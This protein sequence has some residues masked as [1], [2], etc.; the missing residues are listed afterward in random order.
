MGE[1]KREESV[2]TP[3]SRILDGCWGEDVWASWGWQGWGDFDGQT[4]G[5]EAHLEAAG[6]NDSS[7]WVTQLLQDVAW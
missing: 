5:D 7:S 1:E 3:K 2:D 6:V 4:S